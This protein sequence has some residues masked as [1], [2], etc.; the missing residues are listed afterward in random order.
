MPLWPHMQHETYRFPP[1]ISQPIALEEVT[2]ADLGEGQFLVVG[3]RNRSNVGS[4]T[5][6]TR[7]YIFG[8][9]TVGVL[10]PQRLLPC[11][12]KCP[13]SSTL[14]D[15]TSW[16]A[17]YPKQHYGSA[18]GHEVPNWFNSSK[19]EVARTV[20]GLQVTAKEAEA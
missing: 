16:D 3:A 10:S 2:A 15:D 18:N 19:Q 14:P 4:A 13:S 5:G 20:I 7:V 11:S 12:N 6:T 8:C 1:H 9:N 17:E